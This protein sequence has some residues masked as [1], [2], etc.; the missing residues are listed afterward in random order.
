[1]RI[2]DAARTTILVVDDELLVRLDLAQS[3]VQA[4]YRTREASNAAEAIEILERDS[5]IRA[6]FTDIQMPGTLN[7]IALSHYIRKRWP[8]TILVVSSG[9]QPE[10]SE[11]PLNTD[12]LAKPVSQDMLGRVL[13]AI[14]RKLAEGAGS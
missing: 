13:Q 3:L 11:L 2:A 9:N 8:P 4:G 1:M 5:K 6:V 7:G 10:T 12:F 14:E